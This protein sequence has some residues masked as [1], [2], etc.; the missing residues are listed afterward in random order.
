MFPQYRLKHFTYCF[1][2]YVV[3]PIE[4]LI[5]ILLQITEE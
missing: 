4:I 2:S 3:L 1:R 5:I